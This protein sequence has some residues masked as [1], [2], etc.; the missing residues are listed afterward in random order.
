MSAGGAR[1][2]RR[3]NGLD[4]SEYAVAGDV[5][6]RVGEHLLDVLAAGGIAAYLQPSSDVNPVTRTTTVPARPV[7]RLFVDRAHLDTARGYLVQLAEDG[8]VAP[9]SRSGSP[10]A[11]SGQTTSPAS[12][13]VVPADA[14]Q[15]AGRDTD[16]D[17]VWAGIIANYHAPAPADPT[18]AP[19]PAA[20]NLPRVENLPAEG[21]STGR[22]PLADGPGRDGTAGEGDG[23]DAIGRDATERGPADRAGDSRD[24]DSRAGDDAHGRAEPEITATGTPDPLPWAVGYTNISVGRRDDEPSL[25]DGLDTFGAR[26]PDEPE[27]GYTPPLPPPLPRLSSAAVLGVLAIIAGFILFVFPTVLPVDRGLAILLGF[28]GVVGGFVTLIWRLR[29]DHDEDDDLDDGAVV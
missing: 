3:D 10:A 1:R 4:A 26:L 21:R 18:A 6:P 23:R 14:G 13:P 20:E 11:G 25:L 28:A 22:D 27:E 19:W 12:D 17:A 16:V 5:D 9:G 29:P 7:D 15:P 2:G 8:P 24:S